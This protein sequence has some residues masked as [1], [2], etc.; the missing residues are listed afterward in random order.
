MRRSSLTAEGRW[1]GITNRTEPVQ[2][3]SNPCPVRWFSPQSD[4]MIGP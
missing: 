4:R 2:R 3:T 1:R